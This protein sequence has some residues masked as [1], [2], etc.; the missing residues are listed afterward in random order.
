MGPIMKGQSLFKT[1]NKEDFEKDLGVMTD[2]DVARKYNI[3]YRTVMNHRQ[4]LCIPKYSLKLPDK[5]EF[6][7]NVKQ[8][9]NT[10]L[11][12]IY[13]VS[14][15]LISTWRKKLGVSN[16]WKI[17]MRNDEEF[18]KDA[19]TMRWRDISR[20]YG[21]SK[22]A[23]SLWKK[24][25]GLTTGKQ[26]NRQV[27]YNIDGN[28]CWICTSHKTNNGYP[29]GKY[30]KGR[31][32]IAKVMWQEKN[33]D[34][35]KDKICIHSCDNRLCINP[36]HISPGTKKINSEDMASKDRSCWGWRSG[37]RK[38]TPEQ[39]Q[40]IFKLKNTGISQRKVGALYNISGSVVWSIWN[41]ATWWRDNSGVENFPVKLN[42]PMYI[43]IRKGRKLTYSDIE[44]IRSCANNISRYK[45]A[46]MYKVSWKMVNKIL[47][48]KSWKIEEPNNEKLTFQEV[49]SI[50]SM[51]GILSSIKVGKMYK[52]S[53][54]MVI[55]IW[56]NKSWKVVNK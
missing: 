28:G 51:Q 12:K 10:E 19:H 9:P 25:L 37:A 4:A 3:F 15:D 24:E 50:R 38:L 23:L 26:E 20:K 36:D 52:I 30:D 1:I 13:G 40:E 53:H 35:P 16:I 56:N 42:D 32:L 22:S 55:K 31:R 33:G 47:S 34:W 8:F 6:I 27:T 29:Q 5:E 48:N 43:K 49:E 18:K 7:K 39:A 41:G 11:A 46:K 2:A 45:I 54:Q 21:V 14:L 17:D 44:S